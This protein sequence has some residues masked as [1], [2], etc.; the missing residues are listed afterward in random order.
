MRAL[1]VVALCGGISACGSLVTL[2]R[3]DQAVQKSLSLRSTRCSVLPYVFS[4]VS[5]D[6]CLLNADY[7]KDMESNNIPKN[8]ASPLLLLSVDMVLSAAVDTLALPYSIPKQCMNGSLVT[9]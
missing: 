5:Y 6:I 8:D 7:P 4:G 1:V 3:S 2:A 9:K